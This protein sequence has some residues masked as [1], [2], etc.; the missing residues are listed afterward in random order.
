MNLIY[1]GL[2][3][4]TKNVHV[5]GHM[6]GGGGVHPAIFFHG[7]P[8]D[9]GPMRFL[10]PFPESEEFQSLNPRIRHQYYLW[11]LN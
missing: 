1:K 2:P 3:G 9:F 5:R 4:I 8:E 10:K 7:V 11:M 6:Q